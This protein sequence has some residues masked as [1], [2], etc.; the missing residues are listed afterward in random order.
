MGRVTDAA[1]YLVPAGPFSL[2][3]FHA[4][5]LSSSPACCLAG[6][7]SSHGGNSNTLNP[8]P[9]LLFQQMSALSFHFLYNPKSGKR[10]DGELGPVPPSP[11][12]HHPAK[13]QCLNFPH[14]S[15]PKLNEDR[16]LHHF[17][18]ILNCQEGVHFFCIY[19][20][21]SN[22]STPK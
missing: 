11:Q 8:L 6:F 20:V 13:F 17:L 21:S 19:F 10:R 12:L 22:S 18:G 4:L 2:F 9:T 16:R 15:T 7:S 14:T 5:I 1:Q 3:F